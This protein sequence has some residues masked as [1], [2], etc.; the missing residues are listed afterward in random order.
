MKKLFLA[1]TFLSFL[2]SVY[3]QA[4]FTYGSNS[5]NKDEFLRAYNKNKTSAVSKEQAIK[6]YLDL[7]IKFKLK[8]Q[9]AKDARLDTLPSLQSDLQN[10]RGQ[11]E[12]S[13]LKDEKQVDVLV[14]EAF[15]R[16]GK[17]MHVQHFYVSVN[18]KMPPADTLKLYQAINEAYA[19][20]KKGRVD[21]DKILSEIKDKMA[22]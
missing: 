18:E 5:V 8:V 15:N 13:Y 12:E 2:S 3:C 14:D 21:Y 19:Q 20:L 1:I 7:Y 4:L 17:D 10:F 22:P 16:S 9:A 6:D 11:I